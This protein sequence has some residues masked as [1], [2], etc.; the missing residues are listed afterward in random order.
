MGVGWWFQKSVLNHFL[1][2]LK[3]TKNKDKR[4][5]EFLSHTHTQKKAFRKQLSL[6]KLLL[7]QLHTAAYCLTLFHFLVGKQTQ[8]APFLAVFFETKGTTYT[9]SESEPFEF[10]LLRSKSLELFVKR[11]GGAN[12]QA[13]AQHLDEHSNNNNSN[14]NSSSQQHLVVGKSNNKNNGKNPH[15][16]AFRNLSGDAL[17]IAPKPMMNED[18]DSTS[19]SSSSSSSRSS[20]DYYAH[21]A[22]FCRHAS[23]DQIDGFWKHVAIHYLKELSNKKNQP[24]WLSTCG[25]GVPWLHVRLDTHPKYYSHI[26]YKQVVVVGQTTIKTTTTTT[27]DQNEDNKV[28][29]RTDTKEL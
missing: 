5:F 8:D 17:L 28:H 29:R 27:T 14:N 15:A 4:F 18:L 26:P 16:V 13:F 12:P 22:E 24:L 23:H 7:R 11:R 6:S 1:F 3:T 21:V 10:V 25:T 19:F 20:M 2:W 9:M